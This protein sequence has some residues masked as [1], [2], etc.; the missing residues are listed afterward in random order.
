[1]AVNTPKTFR[2][3]WNELDPARKKQIMIGLTVLGVL[4]IAW[5]IVSGGSTAPCIFKLS[6]IQVQ[7]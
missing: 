4:L 7:C 2:E 3:R 5:I 1:M 6:S